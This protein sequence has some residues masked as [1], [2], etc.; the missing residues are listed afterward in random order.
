MDGERGVSWWRPKAPELPV[1]APTAPDALSR[2][3]GFSEA[4][5]GA[6]MFDARAPAASTPGDVTPPSPH[7]AFPSTGPHGHRSR[8]R[9]KLLNRGPDA[10]ADYELLEM[11]LFYAMPKGDTKPLAKALINRFGSFAAVLAAPP[12]DLFAF[13]GLA[14]FGVSALKLVQASALRLAKAELTERPILNNWDRLTDYLNAV[15]GRERI[16]QFRVLFLDS[17]NRLLADELLGRGTVNHTPVYPREILKRALELHAMAIILV[18]N[19]PSGDPSPSDDDID[20]TREIKAAANML[21]IALHDHVIVGN[22]RCFSLRSNG[23]M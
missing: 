19:H 22:G 11:L 18:H 8:M 20:V 3:M 9:D 10:L 2:R 5:I 16:E 23:L 1:V 6:A 13:A 15:L 14:E 7:A 21:Q 17:K 12:K 4:A